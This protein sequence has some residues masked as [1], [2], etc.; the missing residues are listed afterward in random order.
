MKEETLHVVLGAIEGM[1]E[2]SRSQVRLARR[3]EGEGSFSEAADAYLEAWRLL[4]EADTLSGRM[5]K[6]LETDEYLPGSVRVDALKEELTVSWV[7]NAA[8]T[9]WGGPTELP[10]PLSGTAATR[11]LEARYP[12]WERDEAQTRKE[13]R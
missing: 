10:N 8:G 9:S 6:Q 1:R 7:D 13:S 2:L 11:E 5:R 4:R 3:L 12:L